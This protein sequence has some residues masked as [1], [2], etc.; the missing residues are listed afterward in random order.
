MRSIVL[1]AL[2]CSFSLCYMEW[3]GGNSATVAAIQWKILF[4]DGNPA[5]LFTHPLILFGLIG[6]LI[7][8]WSAVFPRTPA[9]ITYA[10]MG[11]LAVVVLLILLAGALSANP[12]MIVSVL[13][14]LALAAWHMHRTRKGRKP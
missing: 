11:M 6:Q 4:S 5:A 9:W 7:L 8:L 12:R 3:G 2:L 13:P 1:L 10:G 14:F